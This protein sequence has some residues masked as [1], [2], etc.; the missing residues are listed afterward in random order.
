LFLLCDE[1]NK[2]DKTLKRTDKNFTIWQ[3]GC[4]FF[5]IFEKLPITPFEKL[6]QK[7]SVKILKSSLTGRIFFLLNKRG[8]MLWEL[9]KNIHPCMAVHHPTFF[10]H[11]HRLLVS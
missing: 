11:R 8:H 9:L 1:C 5:N 4:V 6:P 7:F 10:R 3:Q 2:E